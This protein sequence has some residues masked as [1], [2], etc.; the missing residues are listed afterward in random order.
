MALLVARCIER[1]VLPEVLV[2][3]RPLQV[4]LDHGAALLE[5]L[6]LLDQTFVALARQIDRLRFELLGGRAGLVRLAHAEVRA[7]VRLRDALLLRPLQKR[8]DEIR[9]SCCI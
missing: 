9:A 1:S 3:H 4:L 2:G 8:A 7:E 5:L 6:H